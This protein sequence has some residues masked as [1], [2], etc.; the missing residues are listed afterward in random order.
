[1]EISGLGK[2]AELAQT[3]SASYQGEPVGFRP[4]MFCDTVPAILQGGEIWGLPK[5]YGRIGLDVNNATLTGTLHFDDVLVARATM[6][7]RYEEGGVEEARKALATPGAALKIVPDIDGSPRILELVRL[8]YSGITVKS[9]WSGPTALDL[10]PHA[11]APLAD[12]PVHEIVG[13]SHTVYGMELL[14]GAVL[15]DY[16]AG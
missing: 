2:Y 7:Y 14:P 8:Q 13:S 1:M 9:A 6:G 11:L 10:Y 3:I 12:L 15:H 5:K 4:I 16:L